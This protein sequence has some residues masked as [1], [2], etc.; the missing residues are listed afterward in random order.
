M[1]AVERIKRIKSF[2]QGFSRQT[3]S[4]ASI[5]TRFYFNA[6]NLLWNKNGCTG[7]NIIAIVTYTGPVAFAFRKHESMPNLIL[8]SDPNRSVDNTRDGTIAG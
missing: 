4:D 5:I 1:V 6:R 8:G 2:H 3:D 7:V